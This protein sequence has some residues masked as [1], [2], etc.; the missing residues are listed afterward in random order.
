MMYPLPRGG[1]IVA[2]VWIFNSLVV[3]AALAVI[4]S[5]WAC[6]TPDDIELTI[7]RAEDLRATASPDLLRALEQGS[8]ETK[9]RA[10]VA[11]GRIQADGYSEA[12]AAAALVDS[13]EVR[14][15]ALFALGQIGL[16]DGAR[17][18]PPAVDACVSA[19]EVDDPEVVASAVEALGKLAP[20][21]IAPTIVPL[22]RHTSDT[23]RAQ[24]AHALFRLRFVPVWRRQASEPP[25]LPEGAVRALSEALSDPAA[26]VRRAAAHAF[27]RY[28]QP[29]AIASLDSRLTDEDEWVRLFSARAIGRSGRRQVRSGPLS[30]GPSWKSRPPSFR[31]RAWPQPVRRPAAPAP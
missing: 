31:P 24:S 14:Q 18:A 15:A 21:G 9:V 1:R 30:P 4:G 2:R 19:L 11:M 8:N 7:A 10:A 27:S 6:R 20:E 5:L 12:L 23:V 26:P 3:C 29:D 16:A 25:P 28:G 17:P 22:L 13:S